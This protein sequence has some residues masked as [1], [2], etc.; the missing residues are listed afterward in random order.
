MDRR[1]QILA[2]CWSLGGFIPTIIRV[3]FRVRVR[4]KVS[5]IR[6]KNFRIKAGPSLGLES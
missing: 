4:V 6:V 5:N 3:R 1:H 2:L